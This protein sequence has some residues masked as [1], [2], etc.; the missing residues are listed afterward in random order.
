MEMGVLFGKEATGAAGLVEEAI[1][2]VSVWENASKKGAER[3]KLQERRKNARR[4]NKKREE[5][6]WV[7]C[8]SSDT[9]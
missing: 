1:C 7:A 6:T 8:Y 5:T 4:T 2:A 3:Q 9:I